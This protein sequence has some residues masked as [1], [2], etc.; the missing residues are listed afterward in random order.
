M[1]IR[2]PTQ[3][4]WRQPVRPFSPFCVHTHLLP[5]LLQLCQQFHVVDPLHAGCCCVTGEA[6]H[7]STLGAFGNAE[8]TCNRAWQWW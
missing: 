1:C 5:L 6:G 7:D 3:L 4:L 8:G 2:M